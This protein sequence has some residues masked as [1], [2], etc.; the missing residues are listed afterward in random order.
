MRRSVQIAC[1]TAIMPLAAAT[2]GSQTSL[3][4]EGQWGRFRGTWVHQAE[5]GPGLRVPALVILN[6]DGTV[7]GAGGLLFGGLPGNPLRS[8]PIYGA[9]ERTGW[10]RIAVTTLSHSYEAATG[11]L[12]GYERHRASLDFG[13]GFG[14]Y[15]G[16]EF[17][18]TLS[19][20]SPL[21]CPDPLDPAAEWTPLPTMPATGFRVS[22]AR[23]ELVET[24]PLP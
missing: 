10:K 2:A 1:L 5:V 23:V 22:G 4:D 14:S 6:A 8:S 17:M 7:T 18:E 11:V 12:V 19:C 15:G 21:T 16:T 3:V 20:S 24:G 13:T 9:W